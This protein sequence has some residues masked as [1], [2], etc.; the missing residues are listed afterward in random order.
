MWWL[1]IFF[2][3]VSASGISIFGLKTFHWYECS[4]SLDA[5]MGTPPTIH[6]G[7]YPFDFTSDYRRIKLLNAGLIPA[8]ELRPEEILE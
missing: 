7:P 4:R 2:I 1:K 5:L 3:L 8:D 6:C